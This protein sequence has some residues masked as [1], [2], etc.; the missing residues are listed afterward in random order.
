MY[1]FPYRFCHRQYTVPTRSTRG[2]DMFV[3]AAGVVHPRTTIHWEIV[4]DVMA[5]CAATVVHNIEWVVLSRI[6]SSNL[7]FEF[8]M[9]LLVA[10]QPVAQSLQQRFSVVQGL[11]LLW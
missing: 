6:Y 1:W 3:K 2:D 9:Q 11:Y 7:Q 5:K 4:E 10:Y 8:F